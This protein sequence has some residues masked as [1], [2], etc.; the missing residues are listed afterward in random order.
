MI[1]KA[2]E[3]KCSCVFY[4]LDYPSD[5]DKNRHTEYVLYY[6]K[7]KIGLHGIVEYSKTSDMR[8]IYFYPILDAII[9][10]NK[11]EDKDQFEHVIRMVYPDS[12]TKDRVR[13]IRVVN[14]DNDKYKNGYDPFIGIF[15]N[16]C[17]QF[18]NAEDPE[19][20]ANQKK[21]LIWMLLCAQYHKSVCS[22]EEI[23]EIESMRVHHTSHEE[24]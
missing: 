7:W 2:S 24:E 23:K 8:T 6:P 12:L 21:Y 19:E 14:A 20:I 15:E 5:T 22:D 9:G 16:L 10:D 17:N 11:E 13:P 4:Q 1:K 3:D 18:Y